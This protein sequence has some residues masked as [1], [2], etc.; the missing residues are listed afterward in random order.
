MLKIVVLVLIFLH[1]KTAATGEEM[2]FFCAS[3]LK[4]S[5]EEIVNNYQ[6]KTGKNVRMIYGGSGSLLS[7]MMLS[8]RGD[9]Y[10]SASDAYIVRAREK[11]IIDE[12][13]V[14]T[15][16][17]QL[18]AI[19]VSGKRKDINTLA[20]LKKS[21][22]KLAI[23]NPQSAP[24]GAFAVELLKKNDLFESIAPNIKTVSANVEHAFAQVLLG[25]VGGAFVWNTTP[26][27]NKN[28]KTIK[29]AQHKIPRISRATICIPLFSSRKE[30]AESLIKYILGPAGAKVFRKHG[31]ITKEK[32]ARALAPNAIPGGEYIVSDDILKKLGAP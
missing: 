32:D 17:Y 16:S 30:E 9:I 6:Q 23:A 13:S 28:A 27:G 22:V 4:R 18:P 29:L 7:Q 21:D 26:V 20:D 31:F 14:K 19:V 24:V 3:G 1:L 25:T 12:S 5:I 2:I 10:L 15:V 11:G 8:E